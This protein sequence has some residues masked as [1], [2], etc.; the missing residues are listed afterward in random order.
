M[1]LIDAGAVAEVLW[2][3]C[4]PIGRRRW[5]ASRAG[6]P[7]CE[8]RRI[9]VIAAALHDVGKAN[10]RFQRQHPYAPPQLFGE[11]ILT[12]GTMG[13][14]PDHASASYKAVK[15]QGWGETFAD[16]L[17]GH[18]GRFRALTPYR[19]SDGMEPGWAAARAELVSEIL[20][21]WGH[22]T[23]ADLREEVG[24]WL[25][26][27]V[28]VADWIAS[29]AEDFPPKWDYANPEP[30]PEPHGHLDSAR[31]AASSALA[32]VG[33]MRQATTIAPVSFRDIFGF[34]PRTGQSAIFDAAEPFREPSITLVELPTGYGKSEIALEIARR[35]GEAQAAPG[36]FFA[37]PT[38][39]ASDP[40][41][42]RMEPWVTK[43]HPGLPVNIQLLHGTAAISKSL[44]KVTV[45]RHAEFGD[46][47]GDQIGEIGTDES[48]CE[49]LRP[50]VSTWFSRSKRGMLSSYA[51]GTVDQML[52][53]GIAARHTALRLFGLSCKSTVVVDEIHA[54]DP[55]MLGILKVV[56]EW[57]GRMGV[58]V[59]LL[60]ATLTEKAGRE[61]VGAWLG[62]PV[63]ERWDSYPRFAHAKIDGNVTC[64]SVAIEE[65]RE[66]FLEPAPDVR[67]EEGQRDI[68]EEIAARRAGGGRF[69]IIVNTVRTAQ[70]LRQM[71]ASYF[72]D[73]EV[74]LYH[75]RF[76]EKDR[77]TIHRRIEELCGKHDAKRER[78][79][80]AMVIATQVLEQ[81]I[82]VDFDAVWSEI[83]PL[84]A[85]IQ[86][87]GRGHRHRR[88]TRPAGCETMILRVCMP[89]SHAAGRF[90]PYKDYPVLRTIEALKDVRSICVPDDV[91]PLMERTYLPRE[92]IEP[93]LRRAYEAYGEEAQAQET[94]AQIVSIKSPRSNDLRPRS[95]IA[96]IFERPI[97][98]EDPERVSS[99]GVG[100]TR[101]NADGIRVVLL[102][103]SA[104]PGPH[105]VDDLVARSL[106][107]SN[108]GLVRALAPKRADFEQLKVIGPRAC[109]FGAALVQL[110]ESADYITIAGRRLRYD[111]RLGLVAERA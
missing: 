3:E 108:A 23:P 78:T 98:V 67:N 65:R 51:V 69:A 14:E 109:L 19:K 76:M 68:L 41:F 70:A 91:G 28:V 79:G 46:G 32:R 81:S 84:D 13:Q 21:L 8:L 44:E 38:R 52:I 59:V 63:D 1:H 71:A 75:A 61:L 24:V 87:A 33:W 45:E 88:P 89:E 17:R 103:Q 96:D 92:E 90:V 57:L 104:V 100:S 102:N 107:I 62:R 18:H 60:S 36:V 97:F 29:M 4:I 37:L 47:A 56:L 27:F 95:G 6:L 39:S 54:Y 93:H 10:P 50:I 31:I 66:L 16:L 106:V 7:E 30:V 94:G 26:G 73:D 40:M 43:L 72:S 12:G 2:D 80:F 101:W 22:S 83:A 11:E 35:V 85:L 74:V 99:A 42:E 53:G 82:D 111:V 58:S 110:D 20:A 55:Y 34:A 48:C 86:R 5:F 105:A 77:A 15:A 9:A 49:A 64:R 25:S